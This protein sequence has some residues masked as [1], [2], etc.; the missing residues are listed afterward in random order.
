MPV[1]LYSLDEAL[2]VAPKAIECRV[3]RTT[4]D[5]KAK[6]KLRTKR[7]LY[8][9]K[10]DPS[11]VDDVVSKLGC[12]NVVDVD[13]EVAKR[14]KERAE[15]RRAAKEKAEEK[16]AQAQQAAQQPQQEA[17]PEGEASKPQEEASK[18]PQ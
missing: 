1:E 7:Y 3:K 16:P 2:K 8:T 9:L 12:K 14:K 13:A 11:Q 6:V 18:P 5:G 15:A 10:V 4:R 17:K